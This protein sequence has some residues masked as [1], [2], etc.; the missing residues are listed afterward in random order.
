M[1]RD[2]LLLA[3]D[4]LDQARKLRRTFSAVRPLPAGG[5]DL[6]QVAADWR[7][8]VASGCGDSLFTFPGPGVVGNRLLATRDQG[9]QND[10]R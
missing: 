3:R 1:A 9:L 4:L 8:C 5:W 6:F 10:A 2:A 7:V